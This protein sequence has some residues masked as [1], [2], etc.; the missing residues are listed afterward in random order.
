MFSSN[1]YCTSEENKRKRIY[2]Q[3]QTIHS[4][5][6]IFWWTFQFLASIF[7]YLGIGKANRTNQTGSQQ[8][9]GLWFLEFEL[10]P[11]HSDKSKQLNNIKWTRVEADNA[12]HRDIVP[13]STSQLIIKRIKRF[14]PSFACQCDCVPYRYTI[15]HSMFCNHLFQCYHTLNPTHSYHYQCNTQ[16]CVAW[17][18]SVYD[19]L[20]VYSNAYFKFSF[21][22]EQKVQPWRW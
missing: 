18:L 4:V 7:E 2:L 13:S 6:I 20:P 15:N 5:L 3:L 10:L 14:Y 16:H 21:C 12:M 9:V 11:S 22:I 8:T 1:C 17:F 19:A